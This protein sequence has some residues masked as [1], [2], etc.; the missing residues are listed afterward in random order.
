VASLPTL[1]RSR[2]R[3]LASVPVL[4]VGVAV[5]VAVALAPAEDGGVPL[6]R[7]GALILALLLAAV[8]AV[9][10][11]AEREAS[12]VRRALA[13]GIS[14]DMRTPLA[15]I[16]MYTEML[17]LGRERSEEERIRWLEA[18]DRDAHRLG[19]VMENL[20]LFIHG[21]ESDPFPARQPADLG[22]LLE[23]VA[24][25]FASRGAA[26]RGAIVAD[27]P[28]GVQVVV[29]SQALR[30]AVGNL[31]DNALRY[32]PAGQRITLSLERTDDG[33]ARV[34]VADQ[35]PGI[36]AADRGRVWQPFVRLDERAS[37]EP[38]SGLGLAVVRR[39]VEAH[40]GRAWI[41][42]A[43]GGGALVGFSL[44]LASSVPSRPAQLPA[45]AV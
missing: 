38:G 13:A 18:I 37:A 1:W 32:G 34:A 17:L 30:R 20:L 3:R 33:R 5:A 24:A 25:D 14:H 29:D 19:E 41:A 16:R 2:A 39:V 15:E 28:T 36:A 8:A 42:D 26:R 10:W 12:R 22:A 7:A 4:L 45:M 43:P 11:Q 44:P 23:D 21:D 35:G 40:G 27:P 9:F 31:L 6:V